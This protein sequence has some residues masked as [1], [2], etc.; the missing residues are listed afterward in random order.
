MTWFSCLIH[1]EL[2]TLQTPIMAHCGLYWMNGFVWESWWDDLS[3]GMGQDGLSLFFS[4]SLHLLS[5]PMSWHL[6]CLLLYVHQPQI[7]FERHQGKE[8]PRGLSEVQPLNLARYKGQ[9]YSL[10]FFSYSDVLSLEL[11]DRN[12][13][14]FSL[15]D[16]QLILHSR[17]ARQIKTMVELFLLELKKVRESAFETPLLFA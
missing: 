1:L 17:K 14:Q 7:S 8:G 6:F 15:K 9:L 4:C 11:M 5:L 13:L 12:T 2:L 10:G 3:K 16:E